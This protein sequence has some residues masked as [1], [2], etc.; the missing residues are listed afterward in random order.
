MT[1]KS[2]SNPESGQEEIE[3]LVLSFLLSIQHLKESDPCLHNLY[4]LQLRD[5]LSG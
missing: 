1:L 4:L 2:F 3:D 5:S